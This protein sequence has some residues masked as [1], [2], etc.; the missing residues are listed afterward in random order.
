MKEEVVRVVCRDNSELV[1]KMVKA[2]TYEFT[3]ATRAKWEMVICDEDTDIRAGEFKKVHIKEIYLEPDMVAIP[4]TFT[5]HAIASL[6]K[7]GT[8]G[9]AKPVDNDRIVEYAYILGQETGQVLKGDL[10]AVLNIFPIMFTREA[11]TP[12]E[13][14]GP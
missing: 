9:G 14:R 8:K 3:L 10:L 11:M 5:H 6:I 12:R 13:V 1:C 4:C 7:V 2:A